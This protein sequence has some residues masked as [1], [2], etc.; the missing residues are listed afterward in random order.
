MS[1]KTYSNSHKT[2]GTMHDYVI[3]MHITDLQYLSAKVK[4]KPKGL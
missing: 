4:R 3:M 1:Q 2:Y